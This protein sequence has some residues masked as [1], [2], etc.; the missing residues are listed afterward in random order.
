MSRR[1]RTP[2]KKPMLRV[3]VWIGAFLTR[4]IIA[5]FQTPNPTKGI[6]EEEDGTI[7]QAGHVAPTFGFT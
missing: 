3:R 7:R 4:K 2:A 6:E 5:E 1:Y